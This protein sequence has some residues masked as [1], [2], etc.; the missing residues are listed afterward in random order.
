MQVYAEWKGVLCRR[1]ELVNTYR[2][3]GSST[4]KQM[5]SILFVLV[6]GL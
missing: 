3:R 5:V 1:I 4:I 6:I 2:L